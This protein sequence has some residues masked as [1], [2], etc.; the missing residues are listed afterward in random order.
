MDLS[1]LHIGLIVVIG[2]VGV[3]FAI[4]E[5]GPNENKLVNSLFLGSIGSI[6]GFFIF[7]LGMFIIGLILL[8]AIVSIVISIFGKKV[9]I[10]NKRVENTPENII[11]AT[12]IENKTKCN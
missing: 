6:I 8:S 11:D 9:I 5:S 4:T 1:I 2:V 12:I 7:Y 3:F 10:I